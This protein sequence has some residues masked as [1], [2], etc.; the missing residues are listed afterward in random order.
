MCCISKCKYNF[1]LVTRN[2]G[3]LKKIHNLQNFK[4]ATII[5]KE[6]Y[7]K[8]KWNVC[9]LLFRHVY[10]LE[11]A[12]TTRTKNTLPSGRGG[13][14]SLIVNIALSVT[15]VSFLL[16]VDLLYVFKLSIRFSV[17]SVKK[18]NGMDNFYTS[19]ILSQTVF[20][21]SSLVGAHFVLHYI[22]LLLICL[23]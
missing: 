17:I 5:S 3:W 19:S 16:N 6:N 7:V 2:Q 20:L 1:I 18:E 4:L 14:V 11:Q 21:I 8:S 22:L 12:F 13:P 15:Q 23:H 10:G 9:S